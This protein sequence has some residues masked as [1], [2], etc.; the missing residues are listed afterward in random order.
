[1]KKKIIKYLESKGWKVC[2][3]IGDPPVALIYSKAGVRIV[4]PIKET[5]V[6]YQARLN[7]MIAKLSDVENRKRY[8]ILLDI[9]SVKYRE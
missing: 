8:K 1:M 9:V 3:T 7:D 6:D 4:V 2:A 5:V